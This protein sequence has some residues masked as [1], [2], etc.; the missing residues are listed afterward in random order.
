MY[1][2]FKKNI[3]FYH[4]ASQPQRFEAVCVQLQ[5]EWY[6]KQLLLDQLAEQ[7]QNSYNYMLP[8]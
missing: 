6:V 8:T 3:P 1:A 2:Q 7:F 5:P 4:L